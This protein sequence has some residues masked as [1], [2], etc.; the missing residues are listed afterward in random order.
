MSIDTG[1]DSFDENVSKRP[2]HRYR[3]DC[4]DHDD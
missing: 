2:D 3:F 1:R 4:N